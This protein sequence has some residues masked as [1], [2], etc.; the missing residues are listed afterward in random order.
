MKAILG[1]ALTLFLATMLIVTFR[2][3]QIVAQKE[4]NVSPVASL[5][6]SSIEHELAILLEQGQVNQVY[7]GQIVR[8]PRSV[9]VVAVVGVVVTITTA[10]WTTWGSVQSFNSAVSKLPIPDE[11][12]DFLQ[13]YSE[14]IFARVD[15]AKL[16]A[17]EKA[18]FITK[19]ELV[20]LGFSVLIMTF[21]FGFVEAN[22]LPVFLY[23]SVLAVVI[24]STLL[25][26][27]VVSIAGELSEALCMRTCR[28]YRQFRLNMYGLGVFLISGLLFLF[29]FASPGITRYQ[30][31][32]ISSKTKGFIVLSRMLM[33]LTL[34]IPFAGLFILG[35]KIVGDAGL[36]LTL[37]T[38]C[39]SLVPLKPFD[40]KAVFDYRKEVSVVAFVSAGIL[41]CGCAV[42]L[43]PHVTYLAVGAV[44]AFLAAITL[45]QLRKAHRT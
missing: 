31:G 43:L 6:H 18:P 35:F 34:T 25:S 19:G 1:I 17:L 38:V 8:E 5:T 10:A 14:K 37:M 39:Y 24:P 44:S 15:E 28:I 4:Q 20:A 30:S 32:E 45:N 7:E 41:F 12:K 9:Y 2:S 26:V 36:L 27:S 29:P 16:E 42:N 23:P 13:F 40:G 3:T 22:G 33:L 11:L 21:V